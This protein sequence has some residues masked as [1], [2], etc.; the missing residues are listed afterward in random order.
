MYGFY[1]IL[2]PFFVWTVALVAANGCEFMN[3][4]FILFIMFKPCLVWR[5]LKN[6]TNSLKSWWS[7]FWFNIQ[8]INF[9]RNLWLFY[10]WTMDQHSMHT[11]HPMKSQFN[12]WQNEW[13]AI[14]L[15]APCNPLTLPISPFSIL[16]YHLKWILT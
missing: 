6:Q 8:H 3:T 5:L 1:F 10:C 15:R 13:K 16:Y 9:D 4:Y 14:T 11:A 7:S 12:W 2:F